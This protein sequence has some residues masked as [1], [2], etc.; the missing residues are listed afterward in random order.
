MAGHNK[1]SKIKRKKA[2]NDKARAATHSKAA[3][4]IEAASRACNGDMEDLHLQSAITNAR[5]VQLSKERLERAVERGANPH[6]KGEG[7]FVVK[8]Y[9]GMVPNGGSGKVAVI[10]EALTEN[11]N[12]TAANV[13]HLV[14]KT[15]GEL[16]PTG[17]NDWMFENVGLVWV[18]KNGNKDVDSANEDHTS[19]ST[20]MDIDA[21]LECAL[22]GGATDVDFGIEE[23]ETEDE[24]NESNNDVMIKCEPNNLLSLVQ[25]LKAG[26]YAITQ[27]ENQWLVKEEN[28]KTILD[29]EGEEKFDKFLDT[30]DEDLDVTNVFHNASF[31]K[32]SS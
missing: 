21:L 25:T 9:D 20:A 3:R 26:G 32:E 28:N 6:L 15:G 10:I 23:I 22:E 11:R 12:R 16:L 29:T 5:G 19:E 24:E 14:T 30:M 8:R 1:W 18:S 27:F 17:A 7:E 2:I 4:A 31:A 13:R